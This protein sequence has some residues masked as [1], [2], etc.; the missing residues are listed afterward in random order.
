MADQLDMAQL[1][2]Q[3]QT[4]PDKTIPMKGRAGRPFRVISVRSAVGSSVAHID[5]LQ[6][7]IDVSQKED[8]LARFRFWFWD[9]LLATFVLFPWIGYQIAR[10][11]IRPVEEMA[12]TARH[13]TS[14]NLRER[15]LAR[16]LSV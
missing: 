2:A 11:G 8:L 9:I 12:T 7:A 14:S 3:T 15:I 4:Y 6:I 13:I 10:R 16:R 5:T 1:T